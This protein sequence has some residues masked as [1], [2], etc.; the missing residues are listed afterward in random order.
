MI[1]GEFN[2]V[3]GVIL[4]A[5]LHLRAPEEQ[6]RAIEEAFA[7]CAAFSARPGA[8]RTRDERKVQERRAAF[9]VIRGGRA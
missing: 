7:S 5:D 3:I 1:T 6:M 4:P 2:G 8:A 9:R